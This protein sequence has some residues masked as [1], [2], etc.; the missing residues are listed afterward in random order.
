[1]T[2]N[3]KRKM[4]RHSQGSVLAFVLILM[5]VMSLV[6]LAMIKMSEGS[7]LQAALYENESVA[8]STAE[9]AYERA[10]YWMGQNPELLMMMD[11]DGTTGSLEFADS[12][13]DYQ[14]KFHG[15]VGFRPVFEVTADGYCGTFHRSIRVYVIQASS[16]WEMG[17]CRIP[18]ST[19]STQEVYFAEGEVLDMPIHINSYKAPDDPQCDIYISGDP[20]FLQPVSMGESRYSVGG[21]DKYRGI[22]N[23]FTAGITFDQ[24]KSLISDED[25]V[26]SKID[27]YEDTISRQR[28]DQVFHP[29]KN[30][31]VPEG[32]A[33]VQIEFFVGVHGTGY[34][35]ITDDC[36]VRCRAVTS[37]SDTWD[38]KVQSG[39]D[40][41]R[42]EKYPIYGFHY[43]PENAEA[44]GQRVTRT[45]EST[46]IVANYGGYEAP[47]CGMLYVDGDVIVGSA[48]ENAA[49]PDIAA[50]NVVQ[51]VMSIVATGNIWVANS[52]TLSDKDDDGET[53]LRQ[54]NGMPS[55]ENPNG[56]GL[57]A[58]GVIKVLDPGMVEEYAETGHWEYS[59]RG[60]NRTRV[61]VEGGLPEIGGMDYEPIGIKDTGQADGTYYRHLPDPMV[62]ESAI[63]VGGGGWG[64]ENVR[65][66][67]GDGRKETSGN[68]DDLVVRGTLTEVIR[69]VVGQIGRD[70]YLKQYYFDERMQ[71]GLIPGN[72]RL[73]GKFTT[74]P[75][76]WNDFRVDPEQ[77]D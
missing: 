46:Q 48:N 22:M 30:N 74:A 2:F 49:D 59:G 69:G 9:A 35:R 37:S 4:L 67:S 68:Q 7:W 3:H 53:Y 71:S 10:I 6:G 57:F 60:R 66:S 76:G 26:A 72:V 62:I 16:G 55:L 45:M 54:S 34:V 19:A 31:S 36:T 11:I 14:V 75:G 1:M 24:P 12:R 47:P 40:G 56:L 64:A 41:T 20:S 39:S 32:Q 73:K 8:M 42:F 15:F 44:T 33:A 28:S 52:I 61:W 21:H 43:I 77:D 70:G 51:G 13:A 50:L 23:V 65:R 38:Y 58:G 17:Q 27:W 5:V 63:T 18:I 29:E 25:A